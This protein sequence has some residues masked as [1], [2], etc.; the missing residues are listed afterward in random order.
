LINPEA[1]ALVA[2]INK[3]Q[4]EGTVVLASD[5]KIAKRFTTG[6]LG[7]DIAL[8]GNA[9]SAGWAANQ[10]HEIVGMESHGK[11]A[12]IYK[13][14]AAN[15]SADPD[16]TTFW[17]AAEH[18]D[19]DQAA[20]L[21]VNNDQVI[22][23]SSQHMEDVYQKMIEWADSRACD[24]IVLD[25]YPALTANEEDDKEMSESSMTLGARRTGQFF[26]KV[27][28]ATKRSLINDDKPILGIIINQY[29]DLVG[30][31]SPQGTPKT[32]PGGKGKNFAYIT[33]VEVRRDEWIKEDR[34][35]QGAVIV[36]QVIKFKTI[37]NKSAA[38]QQV[39]SVDF[40]FRDAPTLGFKRGDYDLMKEV[41]TLAILYGVIKRRGA[42]YDFKGRTWQGKDIVIRD[43]RAEPELYQELR[44]AVLAV[45]F[46]DNVEQKTEEELN[47]A[48]SSGKRKVSRRNTEE[49]HA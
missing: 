2:K 31:Y 24:C 23:M 42:Y 9:E 34:P 8:G 40:Y 43:L 45:A 27:G 17:A 33:R 11:T 37:K 6:S 22:V 16:F 47:S 41:I 28:P 38:S 48:N 25:S 19:H 18:Y 21:G 26:R 7:L 10:W 3:A 12:A 15:Q 14:I 39:A 4:G 29:R 13:T 35:G 5:M 44:E 32:T 20:A 30:G 46:L 49:T 1:R 36:G